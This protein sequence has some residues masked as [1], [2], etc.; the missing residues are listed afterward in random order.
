MKRVMFF[1]PFGSFS[2]HNQLDAII[3]TT[4]RLRGCDVYVIGCDG[5][6][7]N[8]DVLAWSGEHANRACTN[9]AASGKTFF[10]SFKLPH[11]Q[12]RNYLTQND[13]DLAQNWA[14][15]IDSSDYSEAIY[16]DLP[17]GKWVTSSIHTYFRI[18]SK[19]LSQPRVQEV[20][21]QFLINGLLTYIALSHIVNEYKPNNMFLFNG[22]MAPYRVA[23]EICR[24]NKID[25][26]THERG[27]RD[28][29]FRLFEN[30][31]CVSTRPILERTHVWENIAL[32][33]QQLTQV[34]EYLSSRE[35]GFDMNLP[36]FY[37]YSTVHAK[38]KNKIKIPENK[39]ILGVFTTSEFEI[40]CGDDYK[41]FTTQLDIIDKLIDVFKGRE[42]Y[43]V[44]R[45]H[46]YIY[47][48]QGIPADLDFLTK[49]YH[50]AISA[51]DNVRVIM[52]YE[53]LNSYALLSNIDAGIS[54]FSTVGIE[55]TARGVPMA[56]FA[57]SPFSTAIHRTIDFDNREYLNNL[58]DDLLQHHENFNANDLCKVYHFINAYISKLSTKF[59]SFGIKNHFE[60]DIRIRSLDD[61]AEGKDPS[62]D[63]VCN[64]IIKGS[65]LSDLPSTED[66][67]RSHDEEDL[68]FKNEL[69]EIKEQRRG[70][71]QKSVMF[72][73]S[74]LNPA[75]AVIH[76]SAKDAIENNSLFSA[77]MG[78]SRYEN[79]IIYSC[80]KKTLYNYRDM[81]NSILS[82]IN[83]VQETY[84]LVT[85]D[86]IYYDESFLSSAVDSLLDDHKLEI[87]GIFSGAWIES[88]KDIIE[89]EIFTKRVPAATYQESIGI[90]P[91]LNN[92]LTLLSFCLFRKE[93]AIETLRLMITMPVEQIGK[94]IFEIM[95]RPT[96]HRTNLPMLLIKESFSNDTSEE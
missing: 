4:L 19:A 23:F 75:I 36:S 53:Q 81:I 38:V 39:K 13:F 40:E 46:P 88:K 92:P 44:I 22:R 16:N 29:T 24:K 91:L 70:I 33:N 10:N 15:S 55:A 17:I 78:R 1:T 34:K 79:L 43:L 50:Q 49:A 76:T 60:A 5:I 11:I 65:P 67:S 58:I 74:S 69:L 89:K 35:K 12:L 18:T 52:P 73:S 71:H 95:S 48:D 94:R 57:V 32:T 96:M 63:R 86:F 84:I 28:D 93:A 61:L 45:H 8:C 3:A 77:W 56:S 27:L 31:T 21:K 54:F 37:T 68:F 90:L 83:T 42:D 72:S 62:L 64:H 87:K 20:H 82:M 80:D 47:G 26:I 51:P 59:N 2:V 30:D 85:N 9:C 6:Y 25:V 7:K 66:I 41:A 14:D